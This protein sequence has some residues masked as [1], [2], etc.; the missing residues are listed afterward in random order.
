MPTL[1][2]TRGLPRFTF[3][4]LSHIE[5]LPLSPTFYASLYPDQLTPC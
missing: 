4:Q 5:I 1:T 2:G 3:R